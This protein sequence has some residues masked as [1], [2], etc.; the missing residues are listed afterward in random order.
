M[1]EGRGEGL[2]GTQASGYARAFTRQARPRRAERN[3]RPFN[4]TYRISVI[5]SDSSARTRTGT[6]DVPIRD[7]HQFQR[8]SS[9]TMLGTNSARTINVS[10]STP[11][12]TA[13]P[14]W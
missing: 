4:A 1:G 5:G 13:K 6:G 12:A 8:R 7:G 14:S 9:S 10:I 11:S 2:P 3:R